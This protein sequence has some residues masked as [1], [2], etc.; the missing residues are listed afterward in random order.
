MLSYSVSI[1]SFLT[2]ESSV[3]I[4]YQRFQLCIPP[5]CKAGCSRWDDVVCNPGSYLS[6]ETSECAPCPAG[7]FMDQQGA[8]NIDQCKPCSKGTYATQL[9]GGNTKASDCKACAKGTYGDE[10]GLEAPTSCVPGAKSRTSTRST[11]W[12]EQLPTRQ[13]VTS[14]STTLASGRS[15]R[16]ATGMRRRAALVLAVRRRTRRTTGISPSPISR[17]SYPRLQNSMPS[18][19]RC[20]NCPAPNAARSPMLRA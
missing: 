4:V 2:P 5:K 14:I 9:P 1:W 20:P 3:S 7:R 10:T 12:A 8:T 17:R 19:L 16:P 13:A 15:K 18:L 11:R 6:D